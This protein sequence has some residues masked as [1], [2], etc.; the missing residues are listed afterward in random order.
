MNALYQIAKPF[1][2]IFQDQFFIEKI[3]ILRI[4]FLPSIITNLNIG[5]DFRISMS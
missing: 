3:Y 5:M 2:E 4:F 1:Q